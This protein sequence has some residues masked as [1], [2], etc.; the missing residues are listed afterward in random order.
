MKTLIKIICYI[1]WHKTDKW[2]YNDDIKCDRCWIDIYIDRDWLPC[3]VNPKR[4]INY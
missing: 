3:E 2:V 4:K 1:F